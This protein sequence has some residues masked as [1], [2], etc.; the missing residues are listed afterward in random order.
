M[1]DIGY[2][3]S[4]SSAL[5]VA[6]R[7]VSPRR[8]HWNSADAL[9]RADMASA[10]RLM[11]AMISPILKQKDMVRSDLIECH[12]S[13]ASV[14]QTCIPSQGLVGGG[15]EEFT[16]QP[17]QPISRIGLDLELLKRSL[18]MPWSRHA[19]GTILQGPSGVSLRSP[20]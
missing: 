10:A 7:L 19:P 9:L 3:S 5:R 12:G 11:H 13:I 2:S 18:K 1:R 15:I 20:H 16:P 14:A 4:S 8:R 6:V 17:H